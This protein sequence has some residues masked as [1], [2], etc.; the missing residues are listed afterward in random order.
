MRRDRELA[1]LRQLDRDD[2][3]GPE[4]ELD[5]VR[6]QPLGAPVIRA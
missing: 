1:P 2:I 3:I 6:R 5:E 4:P